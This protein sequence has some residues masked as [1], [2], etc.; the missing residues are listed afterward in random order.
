MAEAGPSAPARGLW[1][2]RIHLSP[3]PPNPPHL[4]VEL[5]D[6]T[7]FSVATSRVP[8]QFPQPAGEAKED[9]VMETIVIEHPICA[10]ADAAIIPDFDGGH[11]LGN[12]HDYYR[13]NPAQVRPPRACCILS[14]LQKI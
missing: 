11:S 10:N 13:F 8:P 9:A 3:L 14:F 2:H 6:R 5:Q 12:F 1:L 4:E 7:S